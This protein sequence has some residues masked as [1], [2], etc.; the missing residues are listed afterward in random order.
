MSILADESIDRQIVEFLRNNNFY[1]DYI[2]EM[3]PGI[4]D[5]EVFQ[6]AQQKGYI[7]LTADKYFG[8]LLYRQ[9]FPI[10]SVILIRGL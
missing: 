2:A 9:K 5:R 10:S 3:D 8:E 4:T 7:L 6:S 1:V